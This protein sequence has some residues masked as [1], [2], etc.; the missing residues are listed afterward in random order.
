[1]RRWML[2]MV[3]T[4]CGGGRSTEEETVAAFQAALDD[5]RALVTSHGLGVRDAATLEVVG[6]LED[7]YLADWQDMHD[8]MQQRMDD[9][10]GCGMTG[11]MSLMMDDANGMM[12]QLD[13]DV[14]SH[15]Q[16]HDAH[17]DLAQC[18]DAET[19][20]AGTMADG[21]DQ[22]SSDGDEWA[23]GGMMSC[24]SMM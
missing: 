23:D 3:L 8:R 14:V 10:E 13:D 2:A 15:V 1:M 5:A 11:D 7:G 19:S 20:H 4:G 22:M 21:L 24:G 12:G 9:V 17:T 18:R 16:Q 6:G